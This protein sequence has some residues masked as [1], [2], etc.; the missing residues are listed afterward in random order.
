M[1]CDCARQ[2]AIA[3]LAIVRADPCVASWTRAAFALGLTQSDFQVFEDGLSCLALRVVY[4]SGYLAR[5]Q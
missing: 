5:R 4:R 3:A 2:V 1:A